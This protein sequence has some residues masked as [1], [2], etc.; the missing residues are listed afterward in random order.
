MIVTIN[1]LVFG[2][3]TKLALSPP[4]QGLSIPPVRTSSGN[5]SGRDGGWLSS[6]FYSPREIVINGSV[7]GSTCAEAEAIACGLIEA[8]PIRTPL[9]FDF[10]PDTGDEYST[11]VYFIDIKMDIVSKKQIP[12]QITLV[13]PDPYF[14]KN[15]GAWIEED[16]EKIV[17]GGY[18]TPYILPVEWD[19]SSQPTIINNPTNTDIF[20]QIVLEGKFTNPRVANLTTGQFIQAN[21]TT[22][23]GDIIIFDLKERTIT[24]NGGSILPTRSGTWWGLVQG[25]N[26]IEFSSEGGDDDTSG[27]IRYR[28]AYSS[29]FE[30]VC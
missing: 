21:V 23:D 10:S 12:F 1:S 28:P 2:A 19:A 5:Y 13:A 14:Y 29:V 16:I 26:T 18:V 15:S 20:P 9:A 8:L 22:T 11:E 7:N 17:G 25:D 4:I 3:N 6:Q 24:L 30:G 27:I